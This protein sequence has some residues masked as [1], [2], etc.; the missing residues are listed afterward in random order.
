MSLR[1]E[2][3]KPFDALTSRGPWRGLIAVVAFGLIAAYGLPVVGMLGGGSQQFQSPA[4]VYE[5]A[6][7]LA[8][9]ATGHSSYFGVDVLLQRDTV[10]SRS[11]ADSQ[12]LARIT[13]LLRSEHGFEQLTTAWSGE[14]A[15]RRALVLM[16]AF[17]RPAD[18]EAAVAHLR[19]I[20][21]SGFEGWSVAFGGPD[22]AFG[23]LQARTSSDVEHVEIIT[24]PLLLLLCFAVF[25]GAAMMLPL[26]IGAGATV[27]A[28]ALLRLLHEI[29]VAISVFCLPAVFG[30]GLGLGIDYSRLLFGRYRQERAVDTERIAVERTLRTAGRTA[31]VG[32]VSVAAALGCLLV[33][34]LQFLWSI[35]LAAGVTALAAGVVARLIVPRLLPVL[36]ARRYQPPAII[37]RR[38]RR[39]GRGVWERLAESVTA[40]PAIVA[41]LVSI[42]LLLAGAPALG[43]RLLAPSAQLLPEGAESRRVERALAVDF[44]ADPAGAIYTLYRPSR[45]GLPVQAVA[46]TEASIV[47]SRAKVVPPRYLG[48]GTWQLSVL[49]HG[50]PYSVANQRLL[51]GLRAATAATGALIGGVT[52]F[53]VDQK[54][55]I[56]GHL[57]VALLLLAVVSAAMLWAASGSLVIAGKGILMAALSVTAGTGILV[58]VFGGLEE[59]DLIFLIALSLALSIDYE[60]FL[61][62]RIREEREHGL[63]N[64]QAITAGLA[65]TGPLITQAALL[66]CA[67]VGTFAFGD[68]SFTKQFGAG[69]AITVAIDAVL[70]RSL[71]VPSLM[72][73]LGE[74]NWWAPSILQRLHQHIEPHRSKPAGRAHRL[75]ATARCRLPKWLG[76]C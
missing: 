48:D 8:R 9:G 2:F 71:L 41:V 25:S 36:G 35:G 21:R 39:D 32:S 34:P 70:V 42:A 76:G 11:V 12:A 37:Q 19:A 33:F 58:M 45:R 55:A 44:P 4:S 51:E 72:S 64:Q 50:N 30:L 38:L 67:S 75:D 40:H 47:G 63:S 65:R 54:A 14:A 18:S 17:A 16:A 73:L 28:L 69:A 1:R 74:R 46:N 62:S 59:A 60:I 66:F 57:A 29:G 24:I 26:L 3:G 6:N 49:P 10:S 31:L 5:R 53:F 52:A 56:A 7:A 15:G 23:E 61:I 13:A 27:V 20:V 22:V 68:L 43:L